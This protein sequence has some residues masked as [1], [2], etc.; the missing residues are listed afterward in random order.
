M[1]TLVVSV[2]AGLGFEAAV[3][4]VVRNGRGPMIGEFARVLHEMQIGRPRVDAVREMAAR[5]NVAE[6]RAFASAVVQATTL[7]MPMGKVLR[8]Q[9]GELR[10][11]RRQRAEEARP[12]RPGEDPLP[13]GPL[14][15]PGACSSS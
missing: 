7:G 6:L 12:E 9:S 13:D 15:L 4:Q 3:A 11:R 8:Q 2:E 10:L 14:H 5:T 1:D